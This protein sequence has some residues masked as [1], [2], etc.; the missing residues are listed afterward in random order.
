MSQAWIDYTVSGLIVGNIYMLLAVGLALIFGVANLINFAH[1]SVYM[2]GAYIG[3]WC[4]TYV[5]APLPAIMVAVAAGCAVLGV[6]IERLALRPLQNSAR[7]APLLATIGL[8]LVID[9]VMQLLATADPR[10]LPSQVPDW[11]ISIGTGSIGALD[12]LIAGIGIGTTALLFGFLRFTRLGWAVRATALD[13]DAAKQMGVD[14]GRVN[15]TV[16][17][18]ASALG[19]ISGLLVGMYY[20]SIDPTMGQAATLKGI[21]AQLIGGVGNVPG[22]VVGSL[23]LGLIESYGVA[24]FGSTYRDLFAFVLLIVFLVVRPNG[25]FS[26]ART[27]PTEALTGTFIAPSR[28]VRVPV[29]AVWALAG[30][31][32]ALPLVWHN[33]YVLQTLSSAWLYALL[34]IS[35]TL[36]AGTLGQIS[37]GQAGSLAIGG[38]ASA[39]LALDAHVPVALAIPAAGLI[40][41]ALSTA[42]AAPAFRLRGHYI[43]IATLGIGQIVGLVILNWESLTHG[44]LGLTNIPP[45]SAAGYDLSGNDATYWVPLVLL[46]LLAPLQMRLLR[47]HLGRTFRAIRDDEIA[48]RAYGIGLNRYKA[49]GFGFAGFTAG[50]AGALMAH[51]YSFINYETFDITISVLALTMVM[52]GGMGNVLGAIVGAVA[53]ICL[54]ELFRA[55][56]EYRLLIY[57][58]ALL[59]LIRFRP[60]GLLGTA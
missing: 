9:Q 11:R 51:L 10:A 22:A 3:W 28:P 5:Q 33:A 55:A 21:V 38:Y 13:A 24:L 15:M 25:L 4:I 6:V 18:I 52:L 31:A 14:T 40:T 8:S 32:L 27:L 39:L 49:L 59:L 34:A 50:I 46:L 1:G 16:F 37:L 48:A 47:S 57:G 41:A 19:G 56:A 43:T 7:I 36:L 45:L 44:P 42:L 20:N 2:V 35:L 29:F 17:A 23:L 53:L 26:R 58:L 54:P 30:A 60:Q 12:V